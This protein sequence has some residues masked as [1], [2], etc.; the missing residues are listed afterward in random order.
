M[1]SLIKP[2]P[3]LII[4]VTTFGILMHDMH[5]DKATTA[6][7]AAPSYNETSGSLEKTLTPSYHIHVERAEATSSLPNLQQPR[8]DT[9]RYIQNKKLQYSGGGD[10]VSLWP[11]S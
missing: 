8:E 7:I 3:I 1:L 5:L 4:I 11:S 9:R 10:S 6:V 2:S